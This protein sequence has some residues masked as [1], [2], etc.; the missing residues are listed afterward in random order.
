MFRFAA[1]LLVVLGFGLTVAFYPGGSS[2]HGDTPDRIAALET[3]VASQGNRIQNLSGR[4]KELETAIAGGAEVA[5]GDAKTPGGMSG[6]GNSSSNRVFGPGEYEID[7]DCST[8]VMTVY[9]TNEAD[10]TT[11][12]PVSVSMVG[13]DSNYLL[14]VPASATLLVEVY[15]D[16]DWSVSFE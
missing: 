4:V 3:E 10:G 11:Q 14:V 13:D 8:T 7:A 16:G 12:I 6:S 9:A 2:G 5:S 15:C 1:V